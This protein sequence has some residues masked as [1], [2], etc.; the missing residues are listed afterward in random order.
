[1][2]ACKKYK[3]GLKNGNATA[4]G[5]IQNDYSQDMIERNVPNCVETG[6]QSNAWM[7]SSLA[8]CTHF[9]AGKPRF[10]T[11]NIRTERGHQVLCF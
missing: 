10:S 11:L 7:T 4:V 8:F 1:M 2:T 9:P 5:E 3:L 6:I